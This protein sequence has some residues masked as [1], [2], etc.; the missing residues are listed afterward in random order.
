MDKLRDCCAGIKKVCRNFNM[1]NELNLLVGQMEA[2][3]IKITSIA[4]R[5]QAN[6]TLV[7]I[8]RIADEFSRIESVHG[9]A[10]SKGG[11]KKRG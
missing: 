7:T 4:V 8:Q 10:T 5:R 2:E 1:V 3:N 6:A 9:K 11:Q